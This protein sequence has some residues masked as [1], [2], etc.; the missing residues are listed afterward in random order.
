MA[1]YNQNIILQLFGPE[2]NTIGLHHAVLGWEVL[3]QIITHCWQSWGVKTLMKT[4]RSG[5]C[6]HLIH[7]LANS[8]SAQEMYSTIEFQLREA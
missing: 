7:G 5:L 1:D 2:P 4:F 8:F 3:L 6:G